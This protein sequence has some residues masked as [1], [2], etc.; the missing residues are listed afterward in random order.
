MFPG[1][2]VKDMS[3]DCRIE[4]NVNSLQIPAEGAIVNSFCMYFSVSTYVQRLMK[5]LCH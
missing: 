4:A 5:I 3:T 2:P 1:M